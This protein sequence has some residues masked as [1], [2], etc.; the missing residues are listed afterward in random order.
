MARTTLNPTTLTPNSAVLNNAG[1][2]ID[3]VNGMAI[4][5]P[6]SGFPAPPGADT[7]VLYVQNTTASTQTVKVRAGVNSGV[8]ATGGYAGVS[9]NP[10]TGID[11]NSPTFRGGLGDLIT[12]NLNATTGTAWIGPFDVSRF[13]NVDYTVTPN[14]QFAAVDFSSGMTGTIWAIL[15]PKRF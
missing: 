15:L 7:L 3:P 4:P 5:L 11:P 13:L 14:N 10:Y 8:L 12:G 6:L 1:T 9:T 2:A